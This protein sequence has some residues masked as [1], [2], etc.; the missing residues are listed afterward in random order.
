M[1]SRVV[2]LDPLEQ[3]LTLQ[4]HAALWRE[5]QQVAEEEYTL[6]ENLYF[7]NEVLLLL[8]EAGFGDV[9]VQGGYAG[10]PATAEQTMLV[11]IART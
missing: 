5:G 6:Q 2:D 4:M 7:R 1:R 11:F 8:A 3:R 10:T 9:A